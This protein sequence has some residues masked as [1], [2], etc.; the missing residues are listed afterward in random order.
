MIE[1][2]N[3][4]LSDPDLYVNDILKN[5]FYDFQD[6]DNI[7]KN[8]CLRA[9]DLFSSFL[10][11]KYPDYNVALNFVRQSHIN[12]EEPNYIHSDE[13]MGDLTAILYLN[14]IHP[15]DYGTTLYF[16]NKS[17]E[18]M[19]LA[20]YNSCLVFNSNRLHSRNLEKNFGEGDDS[21]L[22]QVVFLIEKNNV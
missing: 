4:V 20:K 8:V 15:K 3:N 11:K 21:R 22:I 5:G 2:Y 6:G 16:D 12:Q 7:F 9:E 14:K 17:I 18:N 1:H 10:N 13:M 19:Y